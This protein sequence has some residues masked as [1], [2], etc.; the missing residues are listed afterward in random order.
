M[1]NNKSR[2]CL[3]MLF[4]SLVTAFVVM[5]CTK[6]DLAQ[7]FKPQFSLQVKAYD[8]DDADVGSETVKDITLY[9]FDK[10]NLFIGSREATLGQTVMLDYPDH[11]KLLVVA[12][13]NSKQ[14]HQTM[15]EL[16]I[17]DHLQTAFLSLLHTTK[18]ILPVADSPDDLFYSSKEISSYDPSVHLIPIKRKISSVII[19]ARHLKEYVADTEGEFQYVVRKSG[20]KLDFYGKPG[21]GDVSYS[22]D[23]AFD[24]AGDF[25]SSVFNILPTENDLRVDIY[26]RGVLKTTI[27]SDSQGKPLKIVEGKL[28]NILINLKG[29][30]SVEISVTPWGEKQIWKEF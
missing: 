27:V 23:A 17:G 9:L 8:A 6:E 21:G 3:Q 7:C 22:P 29:D 2:S 14:G 25:V 11:D 5:S 26:H 16:Q 13:G 12:W 30:V 24:K 19:T 10:G 4:I 28:L 15:P 20:D 18:T 1:Q